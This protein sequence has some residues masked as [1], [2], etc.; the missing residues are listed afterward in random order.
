MAMEFLS[1]NYQFVPHL[2]PDGQ[3]DNF[4]SLDIIQGSQVPC[5]QFKLGEWIG[6]QSLDRFRRRCGLVLKSG[7]NCC[8]QDSLLACL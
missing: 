1:F 7:L 2:A 5:S 3:D 8:F 6:T 4:L